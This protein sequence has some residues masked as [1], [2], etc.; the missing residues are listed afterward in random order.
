MGPVW[1]DSYLQILSKDVEEFK[2]EDCRVFAIFQSSGMGSIIFYV[3]E[4][5]TE[6]LQPVKGIE[7]LHAG[8]YYDARKSLKKL[9]V[10]V[11]RRASL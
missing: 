3:L 2:S 8:F 5:L 9:I 10:Q 11:P 7:Y 6:D 4:L 1:A